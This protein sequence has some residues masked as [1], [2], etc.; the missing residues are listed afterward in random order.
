MSEIRQAMFVIHICDDCKDTKILGDT[1]VK[2]KLD[3]VVEAKIKLNLELVEQITQLKQRLSEAEKVIDFY[4]KP[5]SSYVRGLI[6]YTKY[7]DDS[8][9]HHDAGYSLVRIG[10]RAREYR[11]KYPKE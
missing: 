4:A 5:N 1:C 7:V 6:T 2:C 9:R 10:K 8:T 11:E 3:Q